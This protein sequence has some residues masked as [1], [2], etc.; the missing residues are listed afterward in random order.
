MSRKGTVIQIKICL[1]TAT[2][3]QPATGECITAD[4]NSTN[5][6]ITAV[7]QKPVNGTQTWLPKKYPIS[8]RHRY[9]ISLM[10]AYL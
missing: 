4:S 9:S 3:I 7:R 10:F 8:N 6:N 2:E 5:I 1:C